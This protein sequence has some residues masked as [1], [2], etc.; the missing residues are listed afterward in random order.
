MRRRRSWRRLARSR[1][2]LLA[3][4]IRELEDAGIHIDQS[5]IRWGTDERLE[6]VALILPAVDSLQ[7]QNEHLTELVRQ[8]TDRSQPIVAERDELRRKYDAIKRQNERLLA[9]RVNQTN[10]GQP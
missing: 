4:R 2:D 1:A 5:A 9:E 10:G 8:W 6:T 3:Q 7:K